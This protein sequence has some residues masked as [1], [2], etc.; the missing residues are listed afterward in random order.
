MN[1]TPHWLPRDRP[2]GIR[3]SDR[4]RSDP[5]RSD[6]RR[7]APA[8]L[9]SSLVLLA[10]GG[11]PV[12]ADSQ[13]ASGRASAV[14]PA[15]AP[16]VAG[17]VRS[18]S[19]PLDE[20]RVYL[21]HLADFHLDRAETDAAGQFLF[22]HLPEGLYKVIAYKRGFLPAV[23]QLTRTA[24]DS[25]QFLDLEL[26]ESTAEE[27]AGASFWSVR[28]QIPADVLRQITL[29]GLDEARLA[30]GEPHGRLRLPAGS[31][32][33]A[34]MQALTGVDQI[35]AEEGEVLG[36]R[37]G[38]E[39]RVGKLHI[40]L[41]GDYRQLQSREVAP[42]SASGQ[43]SVLSLDLANGEDT[44]VSLVS[45]S[46]RMD[47]LR[48]SASPVDFEHYQ[49]SVSQ[50]LGDHS[51]TRVSAQYT[52][53]S[54]FHRQGAHDPLGIPEASR[55]FRLAGSY[56]R[57]MGEGTHLETGIRFWQ[58]DYD[59]PYDSSARSL[60]PLAEDQRVDFFG[61]GDTRLQPAVL[62]EYGLYSRMTDGS[63]SLAPR[64][65]LVV[66]LGNDWK[67]SGMVSHRMDSGDPVY[68]FLPTLQRRNDGCAESE[69]SCYRLLFT[70]TGD[71]EDEEL[72]FGAVH[73]E[74]AETLRL[75]FSDDFFDRMES[76]YLVPG[77]RLP[78]VQLAWTR[79][80]A[81][82]ILARLESNV[83]SGGGGIFYATDQGTYEN[84]VRYL[85]TS[86]DTR[87]QGSST[88]L[89]IAFHHLQ[90]RLNPLLAPERADP[91]ETMEVDRLQL[92][93]TQDLNTL[94]DLTRSWAVH[95]N[96]ELSRGTDPFDDVQED[97]ELRKR[98]L[99]G[100]AV[101]F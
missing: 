94:L 3:C 8:L 70:H 89:F 67:A 17:R 1:P 49:V 56:A 4:R 7:L 20:V 41:S 24:A 52:D 79:R 65:G 66:N 57:R 78:E 62:V 50:N 101:K 98:I 19:R 87:F 76:L 33:S 27:A 71:E 47:G 80:L 5:R 26:A 91:L 2:S 35:A 54:N 84:E 9:L 29:D 23:I 38:I 43:S 81:P 30:D 21:Y 51:R 74:Y 73:R 85:V 32:L 88:G 31:S 46:N 95:L 59:G 36:G 12:S 44:R 99:G 60:V 83:A 14:A 25:Y 86:L 72:A 68:D 13:V 96:M 28:S 90:Q 100:I 82:K 61:R 18:A 93:L 34:E 77:D 40:D 64:G 48:A 39:G 10:P 6:P 97:E 55:V 11:S 45:L 22:D 42:V 37:L 69:D 15:K 63:L 53:E 58:R 16:G 92:M 75:Y